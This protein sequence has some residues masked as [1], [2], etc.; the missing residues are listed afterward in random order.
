MEY[1]LDIAKN[2]LEGCN[3]A[4]QWLTTPLSDLPSGFSWIS[5]PLSLISFT[6][7]IALFGWYLIRGLLV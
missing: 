5:T 4:I 2:F 7:L 1:L 6:G 3:I